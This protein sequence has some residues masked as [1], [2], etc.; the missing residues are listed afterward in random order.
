MLHP[1]LYRRDGL[2]EAFDAE[3]GV[4]HTTASHLQRLLNTAL[5][6]NGLI[7]HRPSHSCCNS[8]IRI[9]SSTP[10]ILAF[11]TPNRALQ[12]QPCCSV[13]LRSNTHAIKQ[14]FAQDD[15]T[16]FQEPKNLVLR[17][18]LPRRAQLANA[19]W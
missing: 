19:R 1:L 14:T 10:V 18:D 7:P 17:G 4:T 8:R 3:L 2:I 9:R 11:E 12:D 15:H 5:Q 6:Q 16:W 13:V